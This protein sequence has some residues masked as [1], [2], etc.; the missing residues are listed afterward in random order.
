VSPDAKAIEH[1]VELANWC[2]PRAGSA[3]AHEFP[4]NHPLYG[5]PACCRSAAIPDADVILALE[6][7]DLYSSVHRQTPFNRF[8][9]ET[10]S[11]LKPGSKIIQI[12][13]SS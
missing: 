9:M 13:S 1:L 6:P 8:G 4:S 7:Q 11:I 10:H 5:N 2:R 12:S 3:H